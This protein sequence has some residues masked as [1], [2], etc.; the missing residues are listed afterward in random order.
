[1][2]LAALGYYGF[3]NLGDEA[4]LA[5]IRSALATESRFDGAEFLVLSNA[6]E[7]TKRLHPGVTATDRWSWKGAWDALSG[8]DLFLFGGG[9]LLQ[10]ATSVKS[11]LWYFLMASLARKRAKKLL[12][13]G[14]GIGPLNSPHSRRL[15]SILARRADIIS[16]RDE[17]SAELLK[18]IGVSGSIDLV[19]DPAFALEPAEHSQTT[20]T[21][22]SLRAWP[23]STGNWTVPAKA[24]QPLL[25]LPMHLPEDKEILKPGVEVL[26]SKESG[27]T[28]AETMGR[29]AASELVIAMRLHA[30]IFA[31]RCGVPFVPISYDPK[32][33]ALAKA[34]GQQD[35]LLPTA[36]VTDETMNEM[37]EKVMESAAARRVRLQ[38]FAA[39][40]RSA[41]LLPA[42]RAAEL[43]A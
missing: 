41:A 24:P 34:A 33:D 6:P 22:L 26:D 17:R 40:R 29:F 2:K 11:V 21:L 15:T 18:E 36:L 8:T 19:A 16:V 12:W 42:R 1:M 4:V 3:S 38:A 5:G 7:E 37:V 35:V 10:D 27:A 43:F 20:G 32:V 39:E 25:Y 14:Q 23:G 28:I 30:L 31:A 9:S 13:W